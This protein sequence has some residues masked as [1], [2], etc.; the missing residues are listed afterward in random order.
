VSEPLTVKEISCT[1]LI[2]GRVDGCDAVPALAD[3]FPKKRHHRL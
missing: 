3:G 2:D 1:A